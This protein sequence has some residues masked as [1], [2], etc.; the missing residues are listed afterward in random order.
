MI[1]PNAVKTAAFLSN[2]EQV[3]ILCEKISPDSMQSLAEALST[4]D[5]VSKLLLGGRELQAGAAEE[6]GGV[7]K[8]TSGLQQLT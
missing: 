1:L 8:A 2:S 6:L 3:A 4:N 7:L 5:R